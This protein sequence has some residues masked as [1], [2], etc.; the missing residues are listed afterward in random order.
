[1]SGGA[2]VMPVVKADA[3]G[4]GMVPVA[5]LLDEAG[6]D[7]LCVAT[8]DEAVVLR[9]AGLRTELLVLYPIP[10]TDVEVAVRH[11]L[12][13]AGAAPAPTRALLAAA[14]SAGVAGSLRVELEIE[15]GLG[16]GG[17][18]PDEV[19]GVARALADAGGRLSGVWSH[20][21]ETEVEAITA[22]QVRRYEHALAALGA[23]GVDV[24]RRHLGASAAVLLDAIPRYDAVRPGLLSYGLIP[25]ELLA[26][27][28]A[29]LTFAP[30]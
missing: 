17:A 13:L 30:G 4:H 20:L 22:D 2:A 21:Q 18:M 9:E 23:A 12:T 25:D 24:P 26:P 11:D 5:R 6:V 3:Y 15:T 16:R 14:A 29:H 7:G 19:V 8:L 28:A 10:P 27:D 1:M